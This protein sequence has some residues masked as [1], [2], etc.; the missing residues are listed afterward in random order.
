M[1]I[2]AVKKDLAL[3]SLLM[4][5]LSDDAMEH[6]IGCKTPQEAWTCLQDRFA[7]VSVA[8]INQ[9]KTEFYTAQKGADSVDKFLMRLKS[10]RDQLV[11]AGEKVSDNDLIIA[12]LTGLPQEFDMIRTVILARETS[13]SVKDFGAQLLSAELANESRISSLTNS[14]S[15]MY[16]HGESSNSRSNGGHGRY[17]GDSSNMGSGSYQGSSNQ[18]PYSSQNKGSYNSNRYASGNNFTRPYFGNQ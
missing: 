9:L 10:I 17:Q 8:R 14:M 7:L 1:L 16:V 5:T 4:A 15:A 3:L 13:I 18:R 2:K 6:I 11:S 12:A